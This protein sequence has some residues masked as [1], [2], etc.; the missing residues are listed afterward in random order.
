VY[1]YPY[2]FADISIISGGDVGGWGRDPRKQKDFC[3]TLKKR[4]K[5]KI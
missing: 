2:L 5:Q 4:P 3:T 1:E